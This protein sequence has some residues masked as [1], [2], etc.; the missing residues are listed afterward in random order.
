MTGRFLS[1]ER[2][3]HIYEEFLAEPLRAISIIAASSASLDR[4]RRRFSLPEHHHQ[5]RD[6][7]DQTG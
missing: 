5:E 7:L 1:I 6:A 3:L 4:D 2:G